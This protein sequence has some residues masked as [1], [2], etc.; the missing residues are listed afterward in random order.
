MTDALCELRQNGQGDSP[1]AESLSRAIEQ[2]LNELTG[3][4][5]RAVTNTEKSGILQPAH[6]VIERE[7]I[8]LFSAYTICREMDLK[9]F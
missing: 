5:L 7:L 8:A 3:L 9:M 6:T 4:V 2:K 1:Q